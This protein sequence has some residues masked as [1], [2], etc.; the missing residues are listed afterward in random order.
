MSSCHAAAG[1]S[2]RIAVPLS[3][4]CVRVGKKI[5]EYTGTLLPEFLRGAMAELSQRSVAQMIRVFDKLGCYED[6]PFHETLPLI[7]ATDL[8]RDLYA[9][10]FDHRLLERCAPQ[11]VWNFDEIFTSLYDGG[12]FNPPLAGRSWS[13]TRARLEY[14]SDSVRQAE[15]VER[16]QSLLL[17][18][19]EYLFDKKNILADY[20]GWYAELEQLLNSL[21]LDGF[22]LHQG[23]LIPADTA[24][25]DQPKQ[26]SLLVEQIKT[27]KLSSEQT[28]LHHFSN[29]EQAYLDGKFD[30]AVGEWR[31]FF[32]R[33]LKDIA[34]DTGRNRVDLKKDAAK[35]TMKDLFSYLEEA[36]FL[37]SD[38]K[39]AFSSSWGFLSSGAH[40]GVGNKDKAYLAMVLS[41]S[42]GHVALTKFEAWKTHGYKGF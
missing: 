2:T 13:A 26:V 18:F 27:A 11:N 24:I 9:R 16:G 40:P 21:D 36:G 41:S 22:R 17:K 28:L 31:K 4:A 19:G 5:K 6:T 34:E 20:D 37:D 1:V 33:L 38:E 39:L 10:D 12:F 14:L 23:K 8:K 25:F 42:F 30:T 29:G 15:Q 3:P 7:N 35:L 32:E